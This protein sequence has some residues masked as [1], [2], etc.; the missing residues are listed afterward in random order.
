[1]PTAYMQ[2][3]PRGLISSIRKEKKNLKTREYEEKFC[4]NY[5]IISWDRK[6]LPKQETKTPNQYTNL[7][8]NVCKERF[9]NKT[10]LKSRNHGC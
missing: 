7:Q 6:D 2:F 10:I 8:V 9:I 3:S 5:K 4:R 1:M